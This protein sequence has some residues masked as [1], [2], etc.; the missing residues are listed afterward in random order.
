MLRRSKPRLLILVDVATRHDQSLKALVSGWVQK[1]VE[2][3]NAFSCTAN[4]APWL[5]T[6]LIDVGF[7]AEA[8]QAC[9][10]VTEGLDPADH[11]YVALSHSLR[12]DFEGLGRANIN[13]W[14]TCLPTDSMSQLFQA[15]LLVAEEL[16]FRYVW[17]DAIC[18]IQDSESDQ[19]IES[20]KRGQV[21]QHCAM[22]ITADSANSLFRVFNRKGSVA[23]TS[24]K[25]SESQQTASYTS[26]HAMVPENIWSVEMVSSPLA[27]DPGYF[28]DQLFAPRRLHF[29]KTEV[30]WQCTELKACEL[31]PDGL[32]PQILQN[33]AND[34]IAE[35]I[36]RQAQIQ[37]RSK[38]PTVRARSRCNT[39]VSW[40][41]AWYQL[42]NQ[43]SLCSSSSPCKRLLQIAG[44]AREFEALSGDKY[45]VGLW[46]GSLVDDLLWYTDGGA[47]QRSNNSHTPTWSW[48]SIESVIKHVPTASLFG[49]FVKIVDVQA[50]A[51]DLSSPTGHIFERSLKVNGYMIKVLAG[52]F[53]AG[54]M[55]PD[56]QD[57]VTEGHH[58]LLPL[59]LQKSAQGN[60]LCGIVLRRVEE[61]FV[62][63]YERIG[64]FR[65]SEGDSVHILR[66]EVYGTAYV[67]P[68]N[69]GN[70]V[71]TEPLYKDITII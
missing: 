8:S 53:S 33:P 49:N 17:I 65:F 10:I 69:S 56:C 16:G 42:V 70:V 27:R 2:T 14:L 60:Y 66:H 24:S 40:R 30:Y 50:G 34:S 13:D 12:D 67:F 43:Y 62:S 25:P 61:A 11:P 7:R 36:L 35:R 57:D 48:A 3:H 54:S 23:S 45:I 46:Q 39:L 47:R 21:F 15:A 29:G 63:T 9:L 18:K 44:L 5:P 68:R 55:F 20:P 58:Y 51:S 32:P 64:M 19:V 71:D 28:Q 26:H 1:C 6:R 59:R 41:M 38:L 22:N 37:S 31:L 4:T 52:P